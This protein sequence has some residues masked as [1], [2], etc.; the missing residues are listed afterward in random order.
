MRGK[1]SKYERTRFH[2]PLAGHV[3]HHDGSD[4]ESI[5][6]LHGVLDLRVLDFVLLHDFVHLFANVLEDIVEELDCSLSGTHSADHSEVDVLATRGKVLVAHELGDL[7]KLSEMQILLGGNN[8]D[9]LVK[10]V[11]LV[12]L[13]DSTDI[14]GQVKRGTI[15]ANN[16]SLTQLLCAMLGKVNNDGTLRFLRNAGLLHE[17]VGFAHALTL[18]LRLTGVDVEV[19]VEAGVGLLVLLD[20][21]ITELAPESEGLGV[22]V[23]HALEVATGL[24]IL[25]DVNKL[26]ELCLQFSNVL[27]LL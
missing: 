4:A 3:L 13:G 11:L 1:L 22:T 23:L 25:A 27:T 6:S 21:K 18:D 10:V 20:T 15:L 9:H 14:T 26:G 12:T 8:V 24:L 17:L 16:N 5:G 7:E 2:I 19:N